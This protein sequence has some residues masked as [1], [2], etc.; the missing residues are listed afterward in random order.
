[1][2]SKTLKN[3]RIVVH[4]GGATRRREHSV[5]EEKV[6][7]EVMKLDK[8]EI[9]VYL[10]QLGVMCPSSKAPEDLLRKTTMVLCTDPY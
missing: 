10:T 9:S 2:T 5:H 8:N 6:Q 1:M 4:I 3:R 7:K